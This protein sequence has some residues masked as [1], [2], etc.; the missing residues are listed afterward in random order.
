MTLC[1][2][3][4]EW[5][6]TIHFNN[7]VFVDRVEIQSCREGMRLGWRTPRWIVWNL[8]IYASLG[9]AHEVRKKHFVFC[10]VAIICT[11]TGGTVSLGGAISKTDTGLCEPL[12]SIRLICQ[13]MTK[14]EM[15]HILQ[16]Q[17]CSGISAH[18][19]LSHQ[20]TKRKTIVPCTH[21]TV[22]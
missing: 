7:L 18:P 4:V 8:L 22:S 6:L 12:W 13:W 1:Q 2:Q 20:T 21:Q 17:V 14:L 15:I 3:R 5:I 16:A 10:Y 19:G 9:N 11:S